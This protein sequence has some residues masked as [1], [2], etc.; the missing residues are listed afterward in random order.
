MKKERLDLRLGQELASRG[1]F[2]GA[3][4]AF[5]RSAGPGAD[6][7]VFA[8]WALAL[9]NLGR[10]EE[11]LEKI[12]RARAEQPENPSFRLFE[13]LIHAD[14]GDLNVC[15]QQVQAVLRSFPENQFAHNM[16]ALCDF[17]EGLASQ[18]LEELGRFKV[19]DN[20][21]IRCRLM[22][23]IQLRMPD[24]PEYPD[25]P[26]SPENEGGSSRSRLFV[27]FRARLARDR[28]VRLLNR[29][30]SV[31][32]FQQLEIANSLNEDL[33]DLAF[34]RGVALFQLSR[35]DEAK[36][37]LETVSEDDFFAAPSRFY[38]AICR[39]YEGELEEA[40]IELKVLQDQPA[41]Y[42]FQE[43]LLYFLAC[44]ALRLGRPREAMI[45]FRRALARWNPLLEDLMK[46]ADRLKSEGKWPT[47]EPIN[48]IETTPVIDSGDLIKSHP[49]GFRDSGKKQTVSDEHQ[50]NPS[51][52]EEEASESQSTDD[53]EGAAEV[54]AE[55][56]GT[57]DATEADSDSSEDSGEGTDTNTGEEESP[58]EAHVLGGPAEDEPAAAEPVSVSPAGEIGDLSDSVPVPTRGT[59]CIEMDDGVSDRCYLL[60]HFISHT[61]LKLD[62]RD[63]FLWRQMDGKTSLVDIAGLYY[64]EFG[65]LGFER[66]GS[67]Y[68]RLLDLE[69]LE[70]A[71]D[72][73][74]YEEEKEGPVE[75]LMDWVH[76]SMD[77]LA[78]RRIGAGLEDSFFA[79][80]YRL[81]GSFFA[82]E[83]VQ[84]VFA[85]LGVLALGRFM[86]LSGSTESGLHYFQPGGYYSLA[87]LGLY[88]WNFAGSFIHEFG[89]AM[90][91]KANHSEVYRGGLVFRFGLLGT[92]V[93]LRGSLALKRLYRILMLFSGVTLEAFAG[94][95]CALLS[96]SPAL[97][98]TTRELMAL[99]AVLFTFRIFIHLCPFFRSDLYQVSL[100]T[101]RVSH[102]RRAA[103]RFLRPQYWLR[104]WKKNQWEREELIFLGFGLWCVV[105][106]AVGANWAVFL[107]K[108]QFPDTVN[109]L[110]GRLFSDNSSYSLD[111]VA[112]MLMLL[113]VILPVALFL[114]LSLIY[115]I[116]ALYRMVR[117][118]E[119]WEKPH[120]LTGALLIV[121]L[122]LGY[123]A[124]SLPTDS[125]EKKLFAKSLRLLLFLGGTI[126]GLIV[127]KITRQKTRRLITTRIS[128]AL[129]FGTLSSLLGLWTVSVFYSQSMNQYLLIFLV[130]CALISVPAFGF[131]FRSL[132]GA[133]FTHFF[134]SWVA[135]TLAIG[136]TLAAILAAWTIQGNPSDSQILMFSS[137]MFSSTC[138]FITSSWGWWFLVRTRKPVL[139]NYHFPEEMSDTELLAEGFEFITTALVMNLWD[140]GG[141]GF[142]GKTR[143][144]LETTG[145][146]H[147]LNV[148]VND[149]LMVTLDK[150]NLEEIGFDKL[151]TSLRELVQPVVELGVNAAG[152][153]GMGTIL[154]TIYSRLPWEEREMVGSHLLEGTEWSA[155]LRVSR[156]LPKQDRIELLQN[157][158][159]FH[160]FER[161]EL[162]RIAS[163]VHSKSYNEGEVIIQQDDVDEE[164][165]IIRQG[166]VEVWVEDR[167]GERRLIAVLGPGNFFGELALLEDAQR[168]ASVIATGE[169][170]LLVLGR[171]LF[172]MFVE[173]YGDTREKLVEAIRILR[174]IQGFPLFEEFSTGE[175]A[176]VAGKFRL[177]NYEEGSDIVVQGEVGEEF[178]VIQTGSAEVFVE[179]GLE[180]EQVRTMRA[181]EFFGEI[182]LLQDVPRTAT[183]RAAEPLTVFA[184]DKTDFLALLGG[185]PFALRKLRQEADRRL[186]SLH[187]QGI[188][189][190]SV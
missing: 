138:L 35:F 36:E 156:P 64:T 182:A 107:F 66:I 130:L 51:D 99:G 2:D 174:V 33:P 142:V 121:C 132:I 120:W 128:G 113:V 37:V 115:V 76:R 143:R 108:T 109:S 148:V 96:S 102:L 187:H 111:E 1:E 171:P 125:E 70:K 45:E 147:D 85:V 48:Q 98:K 17:R 78:F 54:N 87:L 101:F 163:L 162:V 14:Q 180:T 75:G 97:A 165:Y 127:W 153:D 53:S 117:K 58:T 157:T 141:S 103:L 183:V 49:S 177:K 11:A 178:Y 95:L 181:G 114:V 46:E 29:E 159:L 185:N 134:F 83:P 77:R 20:L 158:F 82:I 94:G 140:Y 30:Q 23:E 7:G 41:L 161:E 32:A 184:L 57:E 31:E 129:V 173:R 89:R 100:E 149:D 27:R 56:G 8:H 38:L 47:S 24:S 150:S 44:I 68:H 188:E 189:A 26:T 15:R 137:T 179:Q 135:M 170:D 144:H 116:S 176:T 3:A 92:Y 172:K 155:M 84:L 151:E 86:Y 55:T 145:A 122:L 13:A 65:S 59:I 131:V 72:E 79:N 43:Y 4:E 160:L 164:A 18:A 167:I 80:Y 5:E 126:L 6:A 104:L 154:Q 91:L 105:W 74:D 39:L 60:R 62:R 168:S 71:D 21:D 22:V 186:S 152:I 50:R 190:Q 67:L 106:L 166:E 40:E 81:G 88:L 16:A 169:V 25:E 93:D 136:G 110:V 112:A 10:Q 119:A 63:R 9:N 123:L 12:R 133:L 69:F 175:M 139:P 52:S 61:Y 90:A 34:H 19:C 146:K 42:D 118:M 28:G 124:T 73:Y